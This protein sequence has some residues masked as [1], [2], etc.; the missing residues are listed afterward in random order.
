VDD[1]AT[2]RKLLERLLL[3]WELIPILAQSGD[4]ALRMIKESWAKEKFSAMILDQEMPGLG[5]IELM[6]MLH[7]GSVLP[8][9]PVILML[10]RRWNR[11]HVWN[12]SG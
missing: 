1:N 4:E 10:S 2:N 3:Q 6:E 5:G 9:P 11:K 12:V 7:K 8:P